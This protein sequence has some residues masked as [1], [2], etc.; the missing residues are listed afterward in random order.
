MAL[1]QKFVREIFY[2]LH[3]EQQVIGKRVK[4]FLAGPNAS[5]PMHLACCK[6]MGLAFAVQAA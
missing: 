1:G 5:A 4:R 6:P 3:L 2:E